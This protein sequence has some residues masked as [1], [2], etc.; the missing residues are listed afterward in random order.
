MWLHQRQTSAIKASNWTPW[1]LSAG[2]GRGSKKGP[3]SSL[4]LLWNL[5]F[6]LMSSSQFHLCVPTLSS[7][8]LIGFWLCVLGTQP[9]LF[10]AFCDTCIQE[11]NS[12]GSRMIKPTIKTSKYSSNPSEYWVWIIQLK[13]SLKV[14]A[15]STAK[16][17]TP[18]SPDSP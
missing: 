9:V 13:T 5:C 17:V 12:N 3:F 8:R 7:M 18:S 10:N 1:K 14:D 11:D 2:Y 4:L 15:N 6:L 16:K